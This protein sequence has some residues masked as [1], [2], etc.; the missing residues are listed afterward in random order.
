MRLANR[1]SAVSQLFD[2][3][4]GSNAGPPRCLSDTTVGAG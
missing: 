4:V 1:N 2:R 3:G